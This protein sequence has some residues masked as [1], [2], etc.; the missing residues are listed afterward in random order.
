MISSITIV[1]LIILKSFVK[2]L[3]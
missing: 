3:K 2:Y 1:Y